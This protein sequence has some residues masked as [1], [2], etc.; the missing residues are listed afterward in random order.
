MKPLKV[1]CVW[2]GEENIEEILL[3]SFL[4]FLR[5]ELKK[6]NFG[7]QTTGQ[8][9]YNRYDEWP[10]ISGGRVCISK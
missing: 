6:T 4:L 1:S 9:M 7:L 5:R 8:I 3:R 10:L 2:N